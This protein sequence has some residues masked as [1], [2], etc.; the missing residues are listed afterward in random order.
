MSQILPYARKCG[1]WNLQNSVRFQS[2]SPRLLFH[3][4]AILAWV[5][6]CLTPQ[7]IPLIQQLH[8]VSRFLN[9][10]WMWRI[11]AVCCVLISSPGRAM[12]LPS[13]L[14][15]RAFSRNSSNLEIANTGSTVDI[16]HLICFKYEPVHWSK[17]P[18]YSLKF[19]L[20]PDPH[21][22]LLI[23]NWSIVCSN[24]QWSL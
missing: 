24:T 14:L 7:S 21:K 8:P 10:G 17:G 12:P 11:A 2:G 22:K 5:D 15:R 16:M 6:I 19:R 23:V 1:I 4:F 9:L 20:I 3:P 13:L 18:F